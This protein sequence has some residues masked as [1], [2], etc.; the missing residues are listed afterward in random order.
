VNAE[1]A[2]GDS[3]RRSLAQAVDA[4]ESRRGRL[5]ECMTAL[6]IGPATKAQVWQAIRG[7]ARRL[8]A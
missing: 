8:L 7:V 3:I 5:D 2:C 1:A 4:L 6:S